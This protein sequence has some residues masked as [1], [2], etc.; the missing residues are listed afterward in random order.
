MSRPRT[1]R[2]AMPRFLRVA[3]F[4][5]SDVGA[6]RRLLVAACTALFAQVAFR[7]LE[8]WPLKF[9]VDSVIGEVGWPSWLAWLGAWRPGPTL[10]VLAFALLAVVGAR[11][12]CGYIAQ[13]FFAL[14]GQRALTAV[15][16]RLY[17]HVLRLPL[18]LDSKTQLGDVVTRVVG[19]VGILK[20]S[21]VTALVPLGAN[22]FLLFAMAGVMGWMDWRLALAAG[23][24]LPLFVL[25]TA[26][27]TRQIEGVAREQRAREAA[28]ASATAE[29]VGSLPAVQALALEE[30]FASSFA[31]A[32]HADLRQGAKGKRL[33]A[34][35]ERG[36]DL[37]IG[38]STATVLALG[39]GRVLSGALSV[40]EI[41]VFLTYQRRAVRPL[42]DLAKYSARLAKATAAGERVVELLRRSP[43][44]C[45]RADARE[46]TTVRGDLRF[47]GVSFS[48]P[49]SPWVLRDLTLSIVAGE[50][51]G[52]VGESGVGK[53]TLIRLLLRLCDP[54]Q[55]GITLDGTDLRD[56]QLANL[57][58][59]FGVILEDAPVFRGSLRD[60]LLSGSSRDDTQAISDALRV[61]GLDELV[62]GLP[63]GVETR[64][65]ERGVSL[66][67]GQRQR[68]AIARAALRNAPVLLF[69]EP[70][71]GLDEQTR[72]EVRASLREFATGRTLLWVTHDPADL[73][74]LDRVVRVVG[75]MVIEPDD[76]VGA[77]CAAGLG[78]AYG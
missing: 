61:A 18:G 76:L 42:R 60:N 4:F 11:A 51:V 38:L 49:E 62:D 14:A 52:I 71:T 25:L 3:R 35:L 10:A 72:G 75:G 17:H 59:S 69:D 23:L 29:S 22:V 31:T 54:S 67:R 20:E 19:D 33:S 50:H 63:Q 68:L 77:K 36:V 43:D 2:D 6:Q 5:R 13:V 15:R 8:P 70:L 39:A 78:V 24:P 16:E 57:R 27:K 1:L 30:R 9:V 73:V 32:N 74:G 45:E 48:Y 12:V 44:V 56:L 21:T 55:G 7:L 41:L 40:G 46:L 34:A 65:G 53:S 37:L 47:Q 64:V 28:L 58:T 26:R 66:S